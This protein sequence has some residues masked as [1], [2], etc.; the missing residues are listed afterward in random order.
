MKHFC[1][2][3]FLTALV[4]G[5]MSFASAEPV[6]V[7]YN[8]SEDF[9]SGSVGAW[10]SYPPAQDTAY[11]PTIWIKPIRSEDAANRALYREITPNYEIDYV[12][13]VRKKFDV[14]VDSASILSFKAYIKSNRDVDG[15]RVL[16][17]FGDGTSVERTI[18]FSSRRT[19]RDCSIKMA[20]IIGQDSIRKLDAVAFMAL[21]PDADP[22]NLLRFGLDD[23]T[24]NC[25]REAR[26]KF[27]SPTVHRLGE[28]PDFIAGTHFEEGGSIT[29]SGTPPINTGSAAI[30]ISR[31]LTGENEKHFRLRRSRSDK[32]WSVKIPLTNKSGITAGIWRA[33]LKASSEDK[34]DDTISS[35]LVFLVK[36][37]DAPSENPRI[38]MKPG[39]AVEIRKKASS[40][41]MKSIWERM[42]KRA[43]NF[44]ENH[45]YKN[46][47]YN[48]DAYDEV[49][50]LP[51]YGGYISAIGTPSSYIRAN[52][53]VY[54]VS[55]DAEAGDAARRA[56]LKM[57][58]WPSFVHPHILN[59]G[60]FTYWPVGQK[61]TDM[62]VGYDMVAD[63]FTSAEREKVAQALYSKG[64][65]EIFKEYVR[66]NRVSSNTS[67]WIGDVTG[68]GM[69]CALAVMNDFPAEDLEPYL[70]GMILKMN[71]LIE[72]GFG[73]MGAYGEGYGYL[74]HAMHCMNIAL[75]AIE[76][77][78][79]VRFP[80][81]K[82]SRCHETI[83]YQLDPDTY[84]IYDFGDT[85]PRIA[86]RI[87]Q[88][89]FV[90]G[91]S[92]FTYL[93]TKYR[94][95]YFKW[96]YDHAPGSMDVDLFLMDDSV[97]SI[98]PENLPKARLFK[99]VG[100]AVF[101]SG[102]SHDDFVFVF[103]CG[104]FYNHQ[105]FDQGAFY[106]VD[107]GETFLGEV[108]RSNYY[109][110]PWYQKMVIQP[111]GHNCILVNGNPESQRAGDF[112]HDVPA[113]K[114]YAGITDFA[115]FDDGAF[116]SGR[117]DPLYKGALDYLRRSALYIE[118]RTIVLIDEVLGTPESKTVDLLFHAPRKEDISVSGK[119]VE[120]TRPA[121]ALTIHTSAPADYNAEIKKRPLTLYEFSSEDAVTM[122]ARGYLQLSVNLEEGKELRAIVNVLSTDSE[123]LANLNERTYNDHI[124]LTIGGRAYCINTASGV[125]NLN[126]YTEASVTTDALVYAKTDDGYIAMRATS[127]VMDGETLFKA[128][129]PVS[130]VFRDGAVMTLD[131]SAQEKTSLLFLISS[132]P[133]LISIDGEK[134]RNWRYSKKSGLS[135][136]LPAGNGVIGI[137]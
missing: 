76:R 55:G 46:F 91:L 25:M 131:Y 53:V 66:D 43:E 31:A 60:Q 100:T 36:A 8:Y 52:G 35:S 14:Y 3:L 63:R 96:L 125:P 101:R 86:G 136:E 47:N 72:N 34:K 123:I 21:C 83:L 135:M 92:N 40:G 62:A 110:D 42:E 75:P 51:T 137:K 85:A 74:N 38:L 44:R 7:P 67:N 64:I 114:K 94:D 73:E 50:W 87:G 18:P 54:G 12:F 71:A 17:G 89:S 29:V 102:F 23:V 19:W 133:K 77:T 95:P 128:D 97:E 105:H 11:D 124:V 104:P 4:S 69:L 5:W 20:D 16:F 118:P 78:F 39:D 121:G 108:G 57:A 116:V 90:N 49:Y 111:Y 9:E 103:R 15:V 22:E 45:D 117:L 26:W 24:I 99:D 27:S 112:L 126:A 79:G 41:R 120:I 59:Q 84:D 80:G 109:D 33:T 30:I 82:L 107:R 58:E 1:I 115:V 13:G 65:T 98:A 132:K 113:W 28:W 37:K 6:L 130:L 61:L 2:A 93:I 127:L 68:G 134:F 32:R 70:T 122:K 81:E 48:L 106:L 129:K 88:T 56:L 10:S 119:D